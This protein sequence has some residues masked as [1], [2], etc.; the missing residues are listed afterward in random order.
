MVYL[1]ALFVLQANVSG[2]KSRG[3]GP[4]VGGDVHVASR[5]RPDRSAQVIYMRSTPI[6]EIFNPSP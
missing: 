1:V 3:E 4:R 6:A 5:V 2:R